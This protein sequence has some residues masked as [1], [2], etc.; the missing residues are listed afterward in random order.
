MLRE[1][2]AGRPYPRATREI[3]LSSF[4][5]TFHILVMCRAYASFCGMLSR[6]LPTKTLPSSIAWVFTYSLSITQPLQQ[7]PTI[8]TGYKR[9]NK[10][11]I[12][13]D[14]ELEPT[15]YIIV[16]YNFTIS[17][18]GYSVI[19][20]V[21]GSDRVG[22]GPKP[23]STRLNRFPKFGIRIR[24]N[25]GS[26]PIYRVIGLSESESSVSWVWASDWAGLFDR[27]KITENI[28]FWPFYLIY[29][30]IELPN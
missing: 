18:F 19:R 12:K 30:Q 29:F 15:K 20:G 22:F 25:I 8:N 10:I 27:V 14:M 23:N 5:L 21:H 11:T 28:F 9:L 2:L 24:P 7:S 13:F 17:P 4:V 26:D 6:E 16:N 1:C 3:Q